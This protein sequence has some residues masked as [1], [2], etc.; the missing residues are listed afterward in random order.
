MN[1]LVN[2]LLAIDKQIKYIQHYIESLTTY[3][4]YV[5]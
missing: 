1:Q 5:G 3:Q 4:A 2:V